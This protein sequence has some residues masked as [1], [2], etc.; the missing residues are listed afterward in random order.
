MCGIYK[1]TNIKNGKVYVGQ[2]VDIKRRWWE[3]KA[4][5]FIKS[6]D[7]YDKPLYRSMRKHGIEN[8]ILEILYLGEPESLNKKENEYIMEYNCIVPN[9]YNILSCSEKTPS[10][11]DHCKECGCI[12]SNNTKNHLCQNCYKITTRK[13]ERPS[14]EELVSLLKENNFLKV[15]RMFGVSDNAIRKWCQQYNLSTKAKDYK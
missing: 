7:C 1:I 10:P 6:T 2:S 13:V 8:F 3:H 4:R 5:A 12:I 9:G 15:G 11:V 14:A